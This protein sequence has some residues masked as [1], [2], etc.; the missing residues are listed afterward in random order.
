[1]RLLGQSR[2]REVGPGRG[3]RPFGRPVSLDRF[4]HPP[5]DFHRN[6]RSTSLALVHVCLS[7]GG[8]RP[9]R[10]DDRSPVTVACGADLLRVEQFP[11]LALR[12]PSA[13]AVAVASL[14]PGGPAMFTADPTPYR[15]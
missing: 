1:M 11:V 5:C 9:G 8:L 6:G 12:P 10:G 3:F 7:S 15:L 4:P 13:A 14:L 2:V